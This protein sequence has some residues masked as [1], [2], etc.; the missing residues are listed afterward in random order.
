VLVIG[1]GNE[2]R[3]DDG[4]GRAVVERL[5][6]DE[7]L[8][9]V[10]T[11]SVRQLLP[12]LAPDVA[13]ARLVVFVDAAIDV[14]PGRVA[15]GTPAAATPGSFSHHMTPSA[16]LELTRALYAAAPR[17]VEVRIGA[18]SVELGDPRSPSVEAAITTA[19]EAV[20]AIVAGHLAE[21]PAGAVDA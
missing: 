8:A 10:R 4:A 15:V 19:V 3:A 9:G 1:V 5:A 18:A 2:L 12:D 21:R 11:Q 7:R 17:A 13:A 16:L 14:A 6:G 20:A